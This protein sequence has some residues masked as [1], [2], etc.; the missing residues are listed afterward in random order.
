MPIKPAAK[1]A[2][3]KDA[4][5]RQYNLRIKSGV[6]EAVK[7]GKRAI[8][9]EMEYHGKLSARFMKSVQSNNYF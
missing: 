5:R 7:K 2:L 1:K 6:K 4:K 3:R 8:E 9:H